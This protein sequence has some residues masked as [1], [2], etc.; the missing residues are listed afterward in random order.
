MSCEQVG[1]WGL[2]EAR[3]RSSAHHGYFIEFVWHAL[4]YTSRNLQLLPRVMYSGCN[5]ANPSVF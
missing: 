2:L 5:S 4:F 1:A 3:Q